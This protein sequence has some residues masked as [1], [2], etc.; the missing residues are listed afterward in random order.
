MYIT[1]TVHCTMMKRMYQ[2]HCYC[3]EM[4]C[5]VALRS[6]GGGERF[7]VRETGCG[8]RRHC[9]LLLLLSAVC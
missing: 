9:R 3:Q 2:L 6:G 7:D 5:D 8:A 1:C 4:C